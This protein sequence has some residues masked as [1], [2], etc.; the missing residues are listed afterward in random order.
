MRFI[1][2]IFL[3]A[4]LAQGKFTVLFQLLSSYFALPV[5]VFTANFGRNRNFLNRRHI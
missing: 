1:L 5:S 3:V 4:Y 2:T